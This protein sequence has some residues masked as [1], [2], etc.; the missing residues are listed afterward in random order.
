L[1]DQSVGFLS[2]E[3]AKFPVPSLLSVWLRIGVGLIE[4]C[5][6]HVEACKIA[7]IDIIKILFIFTGIK[8]CF[9]K[10]E[11]HVLKIAEILL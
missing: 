5:K 8:I 10:F 11:Y 9:L 1:I 2:N 3:Y 6:K 7:T 4:D